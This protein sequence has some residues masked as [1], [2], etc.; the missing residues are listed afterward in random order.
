MS[1]LNFKPLEELFSENGGVEEYVNLFSKHLDRYIDY[2]LGD[3]HFQG[4][5]EDSCEIGM[6][7][8]LRDAI[9]ACKNI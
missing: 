9:R 5:F 7:R 8:M 2:T 3:E 1:N 4:N 6:L